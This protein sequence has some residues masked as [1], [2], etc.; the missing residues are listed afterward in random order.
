MAAATST[1]DLRIIITGG[2]PGLGG[3]TARPP[4]AGGAE[5][6][7][8]GVLA[9]RMPATERERR[10]FMAEVLVHVAYSMLNFSVSTGNATSASAGAGT[11]AAGTVAGGTVSAGSAVG[12]DIHDATV[13]ELKRMLTAYL[14]LAEKGAQARLSPRARRRPGARAPRTPPPSRPLGAAART[15]PPGRR[16]G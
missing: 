3:A 14:W 9:P 8:A 16:R 13:T 11:I 1:Q 10:A 12:E 2:A 7:I 4:C 5:G 15:P 6:M